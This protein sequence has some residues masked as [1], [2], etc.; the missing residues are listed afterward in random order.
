MPS[1]KTKIANPNARLTLH[2]CTIPSAIIPQALAASGADGV[3]ID[4]E[5]GAID[6]AD[7]QAMIAATAVTDC[8]P[9]VRVV[10]NRADHVKRALDMGAEGIVFPMIRTAEDARRAVASMRYPP[11]GDRG[12]G[13]FIAQSRWNTTMLGYVRDIAPQLVCCLLVETRDAVDSIDAI[14]AVEGIDMLIP[15]QF[16]LSTDLGVMAQFD[17]PDF[18]AA[19]AKIET[20]AKA[21]NMPLGQVAL[22][23]EAA[24]AAYTKG[25]RVTCGFDAIWLRN[26]AQQATD[27][28]RE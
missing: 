16:D 10:E 19:I 3:V 12:F 22:T 9:F 25:Y 24:L 17:H 4:M 14:C 1:F 7:V 2:F 28:A 5:H 15:A 11:D 13:P 26:A 23:R 6:Y 18:L 8:A 27:W 20:A 21:A